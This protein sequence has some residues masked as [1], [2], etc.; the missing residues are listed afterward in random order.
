MIII[1]YLLY[2][3]IFTQ[4]LSF[5]IQFQLVKM[6]TMERIVKDCVIA[7]TKTSV[8]RQLVNASISFVREDS[9]IL[10]S[11]MKVSSY[12]NDS[13]Y[14]KLNVTHNNSSNNSHDKII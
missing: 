2:L 5:S 8:I 11:A 9:D 4:P 10:P 1:G 13:L 3:S 14:S 12:L 7:S 6:A